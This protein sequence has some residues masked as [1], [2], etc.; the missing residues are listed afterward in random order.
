MRISGVNH[1]ENAGRRWV[2]RGGKGRNNYSH[3]HDS[4]STEH[5]SRQ[6]GA[7]RCALTYARNQLCLVVGNVCLS[8]SEGIMPRIFHVVDR[9]GFVLY[10]VLLPLDSRREPK[11]Q[12]LQH[13]P[14]PGKAGQHHR[15]R[16][17]CADSF[18]GRHATLLLCRWS[19]F[20]TESHLPPAAVPSVVERQ[21]V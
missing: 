10:V 5:S 11:Q 20:A 7:M 13:P 6:A 16:L 17:R 15:G 8:A 1:Q 12:H 9:R 21:Q 14:Q 18:K 19:S 2:M 4:R 3:D